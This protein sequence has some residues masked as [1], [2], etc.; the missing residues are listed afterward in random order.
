MFKNKSLCAIYGETMYNAHMY[1]SVAKMLC[2]IQVL[3]SG[4]ITNAWQICL[5]ATAVSWLQRHIPST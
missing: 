1:I 2:L 4:L 5:Q 3:F